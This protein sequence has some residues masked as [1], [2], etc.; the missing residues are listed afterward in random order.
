MS[1]KGER[2][3]FRWRYQ[4]VKH[5]QVWLSKNPK[6]HR[7]L[8]IS[9]GPRSAGIYSRIQK[10]KLTLINSEIGSSWAVARRSGQ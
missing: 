5:K 3:L 1:T 2:L 7:S 9:P 4:T 8:L 10:A 6:I